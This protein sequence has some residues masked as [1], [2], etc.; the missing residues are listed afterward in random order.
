MGSDGDD[1]N[2]GKWGERAR[3]VRLIQDFFLYGFVEGGEMYGGAFINL[4]VYFRL[5]VCI[6]ISENSCVSSVVIA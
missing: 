1:S 4:E 3:K 2:R 5:P 6:V